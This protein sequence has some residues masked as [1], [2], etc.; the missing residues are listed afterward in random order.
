MT[1]N[2][3]ST[4][5]D[6]FGVSDY[7]LISLD[8]NRLIAIS[9]GTSSP[10][11]FTLNKTTGAVTVM[12]DFSTLSTL[13]SPSVSAAWINP[14][15]GDLFVSIMS[16]TD[17]SSE[18]WKT[19]DES[20]WTRVLNVG[21][22]GPSSN[23]TPSFDMYFTFD[24][25]VLISCN[26]DGIY[27]STDGGDTFT[28]GYSD[29]AK[30]YARPLILYENGDGTGIMNIATTG[31]SGYQLSMYEGN[32][33]YVYDLSTDVKLSKIY[34]TKEG[35][36]GVSFTAAVNPARPASGTGVF[37]VY[38]LRSQDDWTSWIRTFRD[39]NNKQWFYRTAEGYICQYHNELFFHSTSIDN[40]GMFSLTNA[41]DVEYNRSIGT[42]GRYPFVIDNKM[43]IVNTERSSGD[44]YYS[45][46]VYYNIV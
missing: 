1:E 37:E 34:E 32:C 5:F 33:T 15:N 38:K 19:T 14:D 29:T 39:P 25:D 11:L 46:T 21:P 22:V 16:Y 41:D 42:C 8:S 31:S 28:K 44:N 2:D 36:V 13:T 35:L 9:A 6:P 4:G 24:G 27:R 7:G 3:E 20:N 30:T 40:Q 12:K 10:K 26:R 23:I 17:K 18:I 45:S 43:I